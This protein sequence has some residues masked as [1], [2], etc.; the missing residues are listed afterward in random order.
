VRRNGED[1]V[2][3]ATP[4]PYPPP[5]PRPFTAS[6]E[7]GLAYLRCGDAQLGRLVSHIA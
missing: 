7:V 6:N 2:S 5:F 1:G 3:I 4:P